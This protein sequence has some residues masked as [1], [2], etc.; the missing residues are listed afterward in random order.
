MRGR[1]GDEGRGGTREQGKGK[2][3]QLDC[4]VLHKLLGMV[5]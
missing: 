2:A 1:E 4:S 5:Q 3:L